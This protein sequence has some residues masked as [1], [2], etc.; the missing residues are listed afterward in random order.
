MVSATGTLVSISED[1]RPV[2]PGDPD[3]AWRIL[4]TIDMMGRPEDFDL[5]QGWDGMRGRIV[6]VSVSEQT[7]PG[8]T[9]VTI[10]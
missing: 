1:R 3:G 7:P 4:Y 9:T 6:R 10:Q 2:L 8:P 5:L